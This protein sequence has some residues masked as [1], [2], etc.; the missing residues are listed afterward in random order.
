MLGCGSG[1][2]IVLFMIP[3]RFMAVTLSLM[4]V[5][6][7]MF[8]SRR[9]VSDE[10]G[11][12]SMSCSV[13]SCDCWLCG[14]DKVIMFELLVWLCSVSYRAWLSVSVLNTVIRTFDSVVHL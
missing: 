11:C 1:S 6:V 12:L 8:S 13:G 9:L 14:V 4:S 3:D 5:S 7:S 2:L 10:V